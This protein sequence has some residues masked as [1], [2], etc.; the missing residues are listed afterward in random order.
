MDMIVE[1]QVT[2]LLTENFSRSVT[3]RAGF[4]YRLYRLKPRAS[5]S[6]GPPANCGTYRVNYRHMISSTSIRQ[7]FIP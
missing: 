1:I 7:N 3:D 5:R 6:K 4:N 2:K